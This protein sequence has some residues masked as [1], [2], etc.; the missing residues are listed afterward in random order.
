MIWF[1]YFHKELK[2][3]INH[4]KESYHSCKTFSIERHVRHYVIVFSVSA[5]DNILY[6]SCER[7][8]SPSSIGLQDNSPC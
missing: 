4:F 8:K 3:K 6:Y 7:M 2:A 1:I 5:H